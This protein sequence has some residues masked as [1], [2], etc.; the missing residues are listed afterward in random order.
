MLGDP[1]WEEIE[2][3]SARILAVAEAV[4]LSLLPWSTL[5]AS[6]QVTIDTEREQLARMEMFMYR[7]T[8]TPGV[9]DGLRRGREHLGHLIE[10]RRRCLRFTLR[11]CR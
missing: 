2:A 1:D 11:L 6:H 5:L 3:R 4:D 7:T 9:A 8:P 10:M